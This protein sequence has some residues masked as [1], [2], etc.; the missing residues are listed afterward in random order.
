MRM[1]PYKYHY[2]YKITNNLNGYFY[3]GVHNTNNLED[4]YMG[5]G[6][7]LKYAYQIFGIENFSKEIL[8]FFN[9]AEDAFK[10]ESEIVT[11]ELTRRIDCYNI[12]QGGI[13]SNT[14]GLA[15]VRDKFGNCFDVSVN[16]PR[17]LSGELVGITKGRVNVKDKNGKFMQVQKDDPRYLSGELVG[18]TK[19]IVVVKDKDNNILLVQKDDP[20]YLSGELVGHSKD[21]VLV[22]DSKNNFYSVDKN[23][24][25]YLSGELKGSFFGRKHSTETKKKMSDTKKMTKS[26]TGQKNSQYGTCWIHNEK[27]SIKIKKSEIDSYINKGWIL[28]RKMKF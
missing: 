6:T 8:K 17:Y 15:T 12:Q 23:D 27:Q 26:Q 11:E 21:R 22:K 13:Y 5:S 20:R 25:R 10:Y 18:C 7:R 9:T 16:D 1:R 3:Y 24:P 19:G 14:L 4:G 2:F 28:G